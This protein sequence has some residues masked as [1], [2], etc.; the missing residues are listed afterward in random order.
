MAK[1]TPDDT[2]SFS[3]DE[4]SDYLA[5][6]GV[7]VTDDILDVAE[8]SDDLVEWLER[9]EAGDI[10]IG[11]PGRLKLPD[12]KPN[13]GKAKKLVKPKKPAV[14]TVRISVPLGE[15]PEQGYVSR[16]VDAQLTRDQGAAFRRFCIGLTERN[17]KLANGK[18]VFSNADALR[19]FCEQLAKG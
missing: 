13:N 5:S 7:E 18:P 9:Y 4:L 12:T 2:K 14:K 19:W 1:E 8:K 15:L 10:P 16:H 11:A 3:R 6:L 17:E